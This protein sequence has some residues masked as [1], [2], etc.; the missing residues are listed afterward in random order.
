MDTLYRQ[1]SREDSGS[2]QILRPELEFSQLES[3]LPEGGLL[4]YF[5]SGGVVTRPTRVGLPLILR[6]EIDLQ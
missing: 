6:N 2:V 5:Y 4:Q 3:F 1:L